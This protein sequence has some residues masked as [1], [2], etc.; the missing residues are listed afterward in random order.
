MTTS[1]SP[2]S[3]PLWRRAWGHAVLVAIALAC[4]FP[5]YWLLATS[6][7]RPDDVGSLSP[8]R[9]RCRWA[10]MWTRSRRST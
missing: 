10:T 5:I 6:L 8:F 1:E 9:G 2:V 3:E 4:I 7:R